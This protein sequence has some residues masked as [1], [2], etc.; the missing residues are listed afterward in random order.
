MVSIDFTAAVFA[1]SFVA[2]MFLLKFVFFD[3]LAALIKQREDFIKDKL[4][5][6]KKAQEKIQTEIQNQNPKELLAQA[7]TSSSHIVQEA[8]NLA[9][10]DKDKLVNTAKDEFN[11]KLESSLKSLKQEEAKLRNEINSIV[12]ELINITIDKLI[13]ELKSKEKALS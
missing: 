8:I 1:V 9:N 5:A 7:K 13:S 3:K 10:K 4:Q 2:F 6:S 11:S 12:S